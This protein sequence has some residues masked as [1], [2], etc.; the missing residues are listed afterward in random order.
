MTLRFKFVIPINVILIGILAASL[1]WEWRRLE[2]TEFT[3]LR[4]RLDE[5]ARFVHAAART[6]G[7]SSRFRDFLLQFCRATDV[8]ASPEH[9]VTVAGP[10]GEILAH[11]AA[12][13]H[14]PI[15]PAGLAALA[16][17]FWSR[18]RGDESYLIRVSNENGRRV[19]VAESTRRLQQR[20]RGALLSQALWIVGL[21]VLVLAVVNAMMSRAVLRPVR[22]LHEAAVQIERGR[23][24]TQV[25]WS[26]RDELGALSQ[27]FNTMSRTLADQ[28][29]ESKRELDAAHKVQAHALPPETIE[30][31]GVRIAGRCIQRGPVGGDVYDVR[32]LPGDRLAIL[33]ADLSGH[34]V[35]AALNTAM[36]R[37]MAWREAEQAVSPGEVLA[38][39]NEQLCRDLPPEHFASAVFAWFDLASSRLL[40]ANAGHPTSYFRSLA[41]ALREL[42]SGGP[43]LGLIPGAEYPSV[44]LDLAPGSWLFA[45]TDGV[46]ETR[47]ARGQLWGTGELLAM[48]QSDRQEKPD[49]LI[50]RIGERLKELRGDRPQ[51]DDV[52]LMMA[53]LP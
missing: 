33:V 49:R 34:D 41:G 3:I 30:L 1:A 11:A 18:R 46:T 51:E 31:G 17:G 47:D 26:G 8:T 7:A 9:Q 48:L 35:S 28:A 16:S 6:F 45:C 25:E 43:V 23:L 50:K 42:E 44:I 4:T 37:S 36:L 5:E 32:L 22:R 12:H 21:G 2:R 38:N 13:V 40:Y 29:E 10:E 27:Q 19:V 52:T 39:L 20:V 53:E 15:D 24:G 14:D